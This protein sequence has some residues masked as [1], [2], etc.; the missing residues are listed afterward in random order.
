MTDYK[1]VSYSLYE[2]KFK[3]GKTRNG[4]L[5]RFE[6][7]DGY[8]YADCH[9]WPE[10]GDLALDQQLKSLSSG[11]LTELLLRSL[12]FARLDREGRSVAKNLLSDLDVPR[13]HFLVTD[14]TSFSEARLNDLWSE[15]FRELKLKLGRDYEKEI[16]ILNSLFTGSKSFNLRFDFNGLPNID[17]FREFISKI[18]L[19]IFSQIEYI[20][21]PIGNEAQEWFEIQDELG[22]TLARDLVNVESSEAHYFVRVAKPAIQDVFKLLNE[23]PPS[24]EMVVTSY[25]DHPFGQACAAYTAANLHEKIPDRCLLPGLLHHH[26][27]EP[28]SFSELLAN[29]GPNFKAVEGTGFGFDQLLERQMWK[30]L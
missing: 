27:Y 10:F 9:P 4:A 5:L 17:Q 28:N 25:M 14:L 15:G 13:S 19:N 1:K 8:G 22:V 3:S 18:D 11:K 23:E 12:A 7:A 29:H 6:F 24:V 21:D 2:L 20:E 16:P 26:V 30:A